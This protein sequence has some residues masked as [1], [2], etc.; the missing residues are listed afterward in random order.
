MNAPYLLVWNTEEAWQKLKVTIGSDLNLINES[1]D[2][3]PTSYGTLLGHS[4]AKVD[5]S[6]NQ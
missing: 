2:V 4:L 5:L 1:Y 6:S 3:M